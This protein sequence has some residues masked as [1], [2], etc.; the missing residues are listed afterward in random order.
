MIKKQPLITVFLLFFFL[1]GFTQQKKDSIA[2]AQVD[3]LTAINNSAE[4]LHLALDKLTTAKNN[5]DTLLQMQW[6]NRIG[7]IFK[8]NNFKKAIKHYYKAKKLGLHFNDSLEL[9]N[10]NF[11]I[12]SIYMLKYSN[13]TYKA[14]KLT[15]ALDKRDTAEVYF[16]NILAHFKKVKGAKS[17]IAQTY[18][19]L[20]GL[21]SYT[22]YQK[23]V[24]LLAEKAI[25]YFKSIHD[26]L[27]IVLV[28]SNLGIN[29]M[30]KGEY[31]K[32][33]QNYLEALPLLKDTSNLKTLNLRSIMLDNLS[34]VYEKEGKYKLSR[35]YLE[36]AQKLRVTYL[37]R[38]KK[39]ELAEIEAKYNLDVA[40]EAEARKTQQEKLQKEKFK[41]GLIIASLLGLSALFFALFLYRHNRVKTIKKELSF[42]QNIQDIQERNHYKVV[43]ATLDGRIKERQSISEAL[44]DNVSALLSSANMHLQVVKKKCG[45]SIE[46]IHKTQQIL[47]ETL[48]KVR[49][50]SQQLVPP[51]LSKFGLVSAV[52]DLCEKHSNSDLE[53]TL[54]CDDTF[55]IL[56]DKLQLKIYN[57]IQESINNILKHSKA[58]KAYVSLNLKNDILTI[59]IFDNGVGFDTNQNTQQ[60]GMGLHQIKARVATLRGQLKIESKPGSTLLKISVPTTS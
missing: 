4:A 29:Q 16:K 40:L 36:N 46:E 57:I 14:Q 33:A 25:E 60:N 45:D 26:T 22:G 1:L 44:H 58:T 55:F 54:K 24:Q 21:Y 41:S 10:T 48:I 32:S 11:N 37:E 7:K 59:E 34:Q 19:N 13:E 56:N 42:Q 18:G 30:Y 43:S 47:D 2:F 39:A 50:L 15:V 51:V 53:F 28:K 12:G 8:R 20:T 38:T 6:H 9:A 49:N 5:N 27:G 23:K 31:K 3:K 17:I 35:E 52:E